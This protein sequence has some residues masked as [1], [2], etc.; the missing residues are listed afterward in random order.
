M[1]ADRVGDESC[2]PGSAQPLDDSADH[3]RLAASRRAGQ[4]EVL[5]GTVH[6]H[7]SMLAGCSRQCGHGM[8]LGDNTPPPI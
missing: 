5:Q 2:Q 1:L 3:G 4:Q 7:H 6:D 8:G